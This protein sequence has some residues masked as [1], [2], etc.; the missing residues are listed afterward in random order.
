MPVAADNSGR[1]VLL[2]DDSRLCLEFAEEV[3][4]KE[5]FEVCL[6]G[7]LLEFDR[8]LTR[9]KPDIVLA[10]VRMPDIDGA[11]LCRQLKH[12]LDTAH[13]PVVLFSNLPGPE[14]EKLAEACGADGFLSK[15]GGF[16]LLPAKL[17]TLCE[18]I[19]W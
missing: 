18:E 13:V 15:A 1:K 5:G 6:A 7:D 4:L 3:L 2:F 19:L 12:R 9:W 14:L 10:D 16:D 17:S 11:E 8:I